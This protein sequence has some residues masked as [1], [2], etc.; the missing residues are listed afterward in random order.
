VELPLLTVV[1][2][3]ESNSTVFLP[4]W[5]KSYFSTLF[6]GN[7]AI[8]ET[9]QLPPSAELKPTCSGKLLS[10]SYTLG[11]GMV[12]DISC[13]CC[14]NSI[15]GSIPIVIIEI[16]S[17]HFPV[18]SSIPDSNAIHSKLGAADDACT[19][20]ASPEQFQQL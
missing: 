4:K 16:I 1:Q 19:N 7:D 2:F 15:G 3:I 8:R 13:D 10:C 14:S 12:H 17:D 6:Q 9:F 11:V 5:P 20:S 18:Y